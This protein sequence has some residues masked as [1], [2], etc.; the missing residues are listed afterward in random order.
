MIVR[1]YESLLNEYN[2]VKTDMIK[3]DEPTYLLGKEVCQ[4]HKDTYNFFNWFRRSEWGYLREAARA[5]GYELP[6]PELLVVQ[7]RPV[8]WLP[9]HGSL[10][11]VRDRM[12]KED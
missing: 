4:K 10:E 11:L 3:T 7:F 6:T 8:G 1:Q 12:A 5:H 9:Q 2:R